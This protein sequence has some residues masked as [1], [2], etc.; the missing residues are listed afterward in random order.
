[1]IRLSLQSTYVTAVVQS[2]RIKR[3]RESYSLRGVVRKCFLYFSHTTHND[4]I[5]CTDDGEAI[6]FILSYR[7]LL[8]VSLEREFTLIIIFRGGWV[9]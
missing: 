5:A 1:M 7:C 3:I 2:E 4:Y 8:E 6:Q 9:C